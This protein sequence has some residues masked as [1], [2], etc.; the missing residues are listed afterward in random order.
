M[1]NTINSFKWSLIMA[2][3]ML[4]IG[5]TFWL[6]LILLWKVGLY[7]SKSGIQDAPLFIS[8]SFITLHS[9]K[10]HHGR[11]FLT[12]E[13]LKIS[14]LVS[15]YIM[16]F[17]LIQI[18]ITRN[19]DTV[20]LF[21]VTL[22]TYPVQF[23]VYTFILLTFNYLLG[24]KNQKIDSQSEETSL[25]E[26]AKNAYIHRDYENAYKLFSKAELDSKLDA[27]SLNFKAQAKRRLKN[28]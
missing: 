3:H 15:L 24:R 18:S 22:F 19:T 8:A 9:I 12:S 4:W 26:Q 17:S 21:K 27:M 7:I 11:V 14:A 13:V 20:M 6:L 16:L 2:G 28:A 1:Q 5:L 23:I 10:K 25:I